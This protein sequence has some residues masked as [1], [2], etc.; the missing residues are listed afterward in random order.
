MEVTAY[1]VDRK[2]DDDHIPHLALITIWPET[3]KH[4]CE[5][6]FIGE[7]FFEI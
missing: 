2:I 5:A 7:Q 3:S 4:K 1:K 6:G